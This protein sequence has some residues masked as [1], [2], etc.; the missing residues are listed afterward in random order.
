[1]LQAAGGSAAVYALSSGTALAMATAAARRQVTHLALY[2]PPFI[3]E[4]GGGVAANSR[5]RALAAERRK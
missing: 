5:L 2:D 3:A 4:S 1:M